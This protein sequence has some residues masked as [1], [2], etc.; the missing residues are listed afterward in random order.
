MGGAGTLAVTGDMKQMLPK[1]VRGVSLMGYGVSLGIGIGIPLPI[2]NTTVLKRACIR[3]S[4]IHAPVVDY[5]AD[6]PE[7]NGNVITHV[8][9]EQL[10]SGSIT[11]EGKEI[12]TGSLSSYSTARE[13]AA[14]LRDEIKRGDFR[15]SE[16]ISRLP[17]D[18]AM[19]PL[20]D[21]EKSQ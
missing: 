11:V 6:Y 19:K 8:T 20:R 5:S 21:R 9:Y 13:I 10:K 1:Y 16:P 7:A 12:P 2:L 18:I 14:I 4:E 15:L 17:A 3:D